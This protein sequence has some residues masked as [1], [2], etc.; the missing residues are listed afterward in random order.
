MKLKEKTQECFDFIKAHG[1]TVTTAELAEGL[2]IAANSVTG[3][4][5]ALCSDKKHEPLAY[6]EKVEVEGKDKP[7]T[8]VHLTEAGMN[9]V[10]TDDD[11]E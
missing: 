9:F 10:P 2:G 11:E 5:N 6:R 8:Y 1:G 3:R 4:V 7:V